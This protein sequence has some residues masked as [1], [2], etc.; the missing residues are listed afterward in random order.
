MKLRA[1]DLFCG[2]GGISHGL[3]AAGFEIV[4]AIDNWK[5]A[6]K[7]YQSNFPTHRLLSCDLGNLDQ[8][9]WKELRSLGTLDLIT[10][11]P[12]CQGFSIQRIGK[13][14]DDRNGLILAFSHLV[15]NLRPRMFLM[16]NVPGLLGHR[17]R[18]IAEDFIQEIRNAGYDLH[19]RVI[20]AASF[21]LPQLRRRVFFVGWLRDSVAPYEFPA[22]LYSEHEYKSVRDA[23]GDL[24]SP[25]GDFSPANGDALHRRMRLSARNLERLQHIPPG[26]GFES[27]PVDLRVDCHKAGAQNI[28]HR[29][30][31]GRLDPDRPAGTITA[32]FDSFTRGRFAHPWENRNISLREGA[33]LQGFPDHYIFVGTQEEIAA[34][35]GNAVPPLV[36][37]RLGESI[38][39]HL[40]KQSCDFGAL[41]H[42]DGWKSATAA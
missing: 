38:R 6:L 15:A 14:D 12:P 3:T 29:S 41:R 13:N 25:P 22:A 26:G 28:G 35:I 10:G 39:Q 20:D 1:L 8:R 34:Q 18:L 37:L 5:P 9:Q 27:L 11:G 23:I 16:E 40:S 17:G 21:G 32:R 33:R 4:A 24:P 7:S 2:A 36:A 19:H 42:I 30:V 31:Y